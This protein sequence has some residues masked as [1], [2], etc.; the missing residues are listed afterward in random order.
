MRHPAAHRAPWLRRVVALT[1]AVGL[2]CLGSLAPATASLA[3]TTADPGVSRAT[4]TGPN[5]YNPKAK[6]PYPTKSTVT[7]SQT[8]NLVNQF[9][10]VSWTGFTPSNRQGFPGGYSDFTLYPVQVAECAGAD[11]SSITANCD[12]L[13]Y[14]TQEPGAAGP[15]T[16]VDGLTGKA[17]SDTQGG[18]GSVSIQILTSVQDSSLGCD[19]QHACSLV[20]LPIDGGDY[21][22]PGQKTDCT[23][24]KGDTNDEWATTSH[25]LATVP[26]YTACAW[27]DRTVV[28][29]RFA[30]N[31]SNCKFNSADFTV[32]G[33]PLMQRAMTSWITK[34]CG[35]S[36]PVHFTFEGT[37]N[38]PDARTNFLS[39]ADDVAL[40]T[41]AADGP[42]SGRSYT[43]APVG[44]SATVFA[45]WMDDPSTGAPYTGLKLTAR[46]AA[47]LVTESYSYD[48][49]GC[50]KVDV[51]NPPV[52][53]CNS[54]VY[55]NPE[56]L[57]NDPDFRQYNKFQPANAADEYEPDFPTVLSGNSDMT[58]EVTNWIAANSSAE[59]FIQ[60][61]PDQW[62]MRVDTNY[63]GVTF[64]AEAFESGDQDT[65]WQDE[66]SPQYPLARVLFYQADNWNPGLFPYGGTCEPEPCVPQPQA[67]PNQPPGSRDLIAIVDDA[68][69]APLTFPTA[70]LQNH[71]GA[72]VTATPAS[73]TAAV[74]SMTT[75]SNGITKDN[76]QNTSN[77]DAYPLTMVV[78]A[79][80]P[81]SHTPKHE[82]EK[83]AQWLDYVGGAG[84]GQGTAVGQLPEGYLPLPASMRKQTLKAAYDVLHQTGSKPPGG[85]N[86]SGGGKSGGSGG[87]SPKSSSSPKPTGSSSANPTSPA[88]VNAA[89][90]NPDADGLIR[91]VLPILLVIGALLA[92]AGPS[93]IVLSRPGGRAAVISGWHRITKLASHIGRKS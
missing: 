56:G 86:G 15:T 59:A 51:K 7:V 54:A 47:K 37:L 8:T 2:L 36:N 23:N 34:L 3:R 69:A 58:Y 27:N 4:V 81:T 53:G 85:D 20:I 61:T 46:L 49:Y 90:S 42:A 1:S 5:M 82:A 13:T 43:Y 75:S 68:D 17:V 70:A 55:G 89:Y 6:A 31:N 62:G 22:G 32:A 16:E 83:I 87:S 66:Y 50:T 19:E 11:P 35:G 14:M 65:L 92:L 63:L 39:G 38:E 41:E 74:D 48:G 33:S 40:T 29:L 76:N 93:A 91:W 78:Y 21:G 88:K 71:A 57:F 12:G 28:P 67:N 44:I 60:G 26:D 80:V 73:M 30:P 79:M 9:V 64:P 52:N 84:Q 25:V 24:H 18:T 10:T 45:Y 72:F 77:P